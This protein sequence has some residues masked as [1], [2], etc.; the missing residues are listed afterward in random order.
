VHPEQAPFACAGQERGPCR[1]FLAVFHASSCVPEDLRSSGWG[2]LALLWSFCNWGYYGQ[3][4][5]SSL[6]VC[7]RWIFIQ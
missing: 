4:R 6:P 7:Q 5:T 2:K 1:E 3:Q